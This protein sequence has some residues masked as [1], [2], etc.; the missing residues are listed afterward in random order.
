ML[1]DLREMEDI[2][3]FFFTTLD[4]SIWNLKKI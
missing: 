3:D 1:N 2:N 4:F